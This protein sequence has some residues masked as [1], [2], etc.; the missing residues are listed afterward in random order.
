VG[1]LAVELA[2]IFWALPIYG[3]QVTRAAVFTSMVLCNLGLILL[4]RAGKRSLIKTLLTP[5]VPQAWV[6]IGSLGLLGLSLSVPWVQKLFMFAPI[7]PEV[8]GLSVIAAFASIAASN[9]VRRWNIA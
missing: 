2:F 5:N 4:S 9:I 6:T 8:L 1:E 3:E 7:P